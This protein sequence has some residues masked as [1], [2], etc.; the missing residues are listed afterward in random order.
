ME[1]YTAAVEDMRFLL[2]RVFDFEPVLSRATASEVDA[3]T[4]FSVL[5][6]G[7]QF[8]AKVLAPAGVTGDQIGSRF[9]DGA[10]V[11]PPGFK[12]CYRRY[13]EDGWLGVDLP[14]QF[15]GQGLPL[16]VQA[17]LAEMVTGAY[18]A[19]S[20]LTLQGRSAARLLIGHAEAAVRDALVPRLVS[21]EWAAT[22]CITEP[23]AGSDVGRL[24]TR[25]VRQDNGQW[26]LSG[27]KIFISYADQDVTPQILHMALARTPGAP[28]GTR[29]LSLFI[30]PKFK[31]DA[32]WQPGERNPAR[33]QHIEHKMGLSASA[34]CELHLDG[35]QGFMI[36]EE[37]QG[38]KA[39]FDMMNVMRLETGI[40]GIGVGAA[41]M[42]KALAYTVERTQGG[43]A[44]APP[45]PLTA[46]ADVRRMIYTM[47]ARVEAMRAM[48]FET[49]LQLDLSYA[50]PDAGTRATAR[51]QVQWLL[52]ICKAFF[53]DTGFEVANLAIQCHGG[54]GYIRETD[55]ERH[56]RDLRVASIYE[57]TNGI[58]AFDLV[59][60]K[61]LPDG[62]KRYQ[63]F[64]RRIR[65]DLA[66]TK[67]RAGLDDI[68]Q[69]LTHAADA[70][71]RV[72]QTYLAQP[73]AQRRDAETG[74]AAYLSLIGRVASGWMWLRMATAA[75][76]D[77]PLHRRKRELAR[78]YARYL[79][80]EVL[81][82]E[83]QASA[84]AA[85]IDGLDAETLVDYR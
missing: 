38:L 16:M 57:G 81:A 27:T 21:G 79:L 66:A 46:H 2:E 26:A 36:G 28:A 43:P 71:D 74:A 33:V 30:V 76:E 60:R 5:E 29:G 13:C 50:A 69:A 64:M 78:F 68:R 11:T 58:Q 10:V 19:F 17:G 1:H 56:V 77:M 51:E 31:L 14:A 25:A 34:T 67:D 8:A 54:H 53:T 39:M 62:G 40:Q 45:T 35:A 70:A 22:I 32:N 4:A 82:L 12:E 49:A 73:P 48:M 83:Q 75:S 20:M 55:V 42:A 65:A 41:A 23:Q 52:P 7:A 59:A 6:Q 9:V 18:M 84:S 47:R 3:Q 15:G 72:T 61:L 80:P 24:T 85:W 37:G 44:D 63:E